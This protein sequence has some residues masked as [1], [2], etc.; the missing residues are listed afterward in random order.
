MYIRERLY[1]IYIYIC[2]HC[3]NTYF[4]FNSLA[5]ADEDDLE[6]ELLALTGGKSTKKGGK[7]PKGGDSGHMSLADIDKMVASVKD[8]GDGDEE[9]ADMSDLDDD[10]LLSE[11]RVSHSCSKIH[12]P[13]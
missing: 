2:I 1:N 7:K 6:A 13:I 5:G 9:D 12:L 4:Y 10:D 11:L 3:G 8:I